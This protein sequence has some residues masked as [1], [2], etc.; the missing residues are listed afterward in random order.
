LNYEGPDGVFFSFILLT[1]AFFPCARQALKR[2]VTLG[3]LGFNLLF[4]IG[5]R[6]GIPLSGWI[7]ARMPDGRLS[8]ALADYFSYGTFSPGDLIAI[9]L[10]ALAGYVYVGTFGPGGQP[11]GRLRAIP[12]PSRSSHPSPFILIATKRAPV[13][14]IAFPHGSISLQ[15]YNQS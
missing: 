4:E 5:Q 3:W 1:L 14:L 11:H 12:L 10:G 13:D 8:S 2:F 7:A 15:P 6:D 9:V